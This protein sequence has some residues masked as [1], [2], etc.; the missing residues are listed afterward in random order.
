MGA[1]IKRQEG[2]GSG[3][4]AVAMSTSLPAGSASVQRRCSSLWRT[5]RPP[6]ARAAV[7]RESARS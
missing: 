7:T 2:V 4:D 1:Y 3:A 6:A 5:S